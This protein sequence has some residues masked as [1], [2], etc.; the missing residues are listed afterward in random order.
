MGQWQLIVA[1]DKCCV[2][3]IGKVDNNCT[4]FSI[5]SGTLPIV[6]Q[7]RDLGVTVSHDLK[8]TEHIN[9]IIIKANQRAHSIHRCFVSRD[10][11]LLL[12]AYTVYVRPLLE[13]NSVVWSPSLKKDIEAIERVQRTFTK[14]LPGLRNCSYSERLA[15]LNISSLELRRLYFDLEWC[16]KF[17]FGLVCMPTDQKMFE[18]RLSSNTRGHMYKLYK[19]RNRNS[20]RSA[21]FTERVINVWNSLPGDTVDFSSITAFKRTIELVNHSAFLT[22]F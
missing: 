8:P 20:I 13:F 9:S 18:L 10:V 3:N 4:N 14:R 21:F 11:Q 7:C 15:L 12:R 17:V 16:Y 6:K 22:C 1:F 5:D 2:L 19:K